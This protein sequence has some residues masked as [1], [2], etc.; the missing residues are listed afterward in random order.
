MSINWD[1]SE[2]WESRVSRLKAQFKEK[3]DQARLNRT[4][5]S[6]KEQNLF[7]DLR[8]HVNGH[9]SVDFETITAVLLEHGGEYDFYP[10]PDTDIILAEQLSNSKKVLYL[11]SLRIRTCEIG[12]F[13]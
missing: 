9:L 13:I 3:H 5:K 8:F 2:Y 10:T 12:K 11:V 4:K 7:K 1:P 6:D